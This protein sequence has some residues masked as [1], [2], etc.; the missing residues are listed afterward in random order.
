MTVFSYQ[1]VCTARGCHSPAAY[2]VAARWTDG[3]TEE[4][5]TYDLTC[6]DCLAAAYRQSLLKQ[7]SCRLTAGEVL[8]LPGIYELERGRRDGQLRRRVDLE[9]GL[10]AVEPL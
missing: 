3:I 9:A 2:K 6:E 4:L 5:K 10:P 8:E 7:K 1:V